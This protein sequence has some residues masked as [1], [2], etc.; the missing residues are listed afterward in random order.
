MMD[1][2][3]DNDKGDAMSGEGLA[4]GILGTAAENPALPLRCSYSRAEMIERARDFI[5]E[6]YGP[7]QASA[8]R[9]HWH[10]RFGLLVNFINEQFPAS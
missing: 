10:E 5:T 6:M 4:N 9:D 3:N 2:R 1:Q 8:D 7:C